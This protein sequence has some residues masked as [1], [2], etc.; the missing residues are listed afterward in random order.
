MTEK[1]LRQLKRKRDH[2]DVTLDATAMVLQSVASTACPG[3]KMWYSV[4]NACYLI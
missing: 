2:W 4:P 3:D 1:A